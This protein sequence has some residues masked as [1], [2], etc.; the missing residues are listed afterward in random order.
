MSYRE[1]L[2]AVERLGVRRSP[3]D[4]G[5]YDVP[6]DSVPYAD[7]APFRHVADEIDVASWRFSG[8]V[9][10]EYKPEPGTPEWFAVRCLQLVVIHRQDRQGQRLA[11]F[12]PQ[13]MWFLRLAADQLVG[14]KH[15]PDFRSVSWFGMDY[16]FSANQAAAV[17][18]LW[19]AFEKGTP[20][21]GDQHLLHRADSKAR[22]IKDV[23]KGHPAWGTMIV[24]GST[25]GTRRLS[26]EKK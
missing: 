13:A 4:G 21:V 8:S 2:D 1:L 10:Q 3:D 18:T 7:L 17:G 26:A 15:S 14:C 20:D 6:W 25:K 9:H 16:S 22:Y 24:E 11:D 19:S 23:F 12:P 5:R